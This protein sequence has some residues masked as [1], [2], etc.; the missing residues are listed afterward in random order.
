VRIVG[1]SFK[2]R[3]QFPKQG[4]DSA[5][6]LRNILTTGLLT[7]TLEDSITGKIVANVE[8][9]RV[10]ERNITVTA[11]GIVGENVTMVAI[12]ARDESDLSA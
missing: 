11:R 3:G 4:A 5:T 12:R 7:A 9:V 6:F 10:A 1:D 2:S 8:G